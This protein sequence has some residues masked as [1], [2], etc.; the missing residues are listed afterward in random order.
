MSAV[1]LCMCSCSSSRP[2]IFLSSIL[3]R[4]LPLVCIVDGLR[5]LVF[6][7]T[8]LFDFISPISHPDGNSDRGDASTVFGFIIPLLFF[9]VSLSTHRQLPQ[10]PHCSAMVATST[11]AP[12][13]II[14]GVA[15]SDVR[16]TLQ[17]F[18]CKV[19]KRNESDWLSLQA[20]PIFS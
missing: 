1:V 3:H 10:T 8:F 15:G 14:V 13:A 7:M 16:A 2:R 19:V 20:G 5:R 9:S 12:T 4:D 11:L 6:G 17:L 18:K